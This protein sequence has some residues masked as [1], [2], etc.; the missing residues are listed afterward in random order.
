MKRKNPNSEQYPTLNGRRRGFTLIELLTV[1]SIIAVLGAVAM[2]VMKTA[3]EMAKISAAMQNARQV[4]IGLRAYAMDSGGI[5][6][7]GENDLGE[8]ITSSNAAFR[9]LIEYIDDERVYAVAGSAWGTEADNKDPYCS[10]GEVHFGY[11]AG[12]STSSKSWWPLVVDGTDGSGSY[13]RDRGQ[14]GGLWGGKKAV[15]ARVDGSA[16]TMKL[17]GD[18]NARYIPQLDNEGENALQVSSYMGSAAEYYDPEG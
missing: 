4:G 15:V 17:K 6:P 5:F 2:P 11:V 1:M 14:R 18:D 12:L 9:D 13:N 16:T 10:A 3:M 8:S 7:S